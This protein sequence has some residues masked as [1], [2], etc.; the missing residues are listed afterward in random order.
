MFRTRTTLLDTLLKSTLAL[1]V[2]AL[3]LLVVF[4]AYS[5][6]NQRDA[7]VPPDP[8]IVLGK[9]L[10]VVV[11]TGDVAGDALEITGYEPRNG[12]LAAVA[13][14]R[15]RV[16]A[17]DYPLLKYQVDTEFPGPALKLVWH[18]QDSPGTLMS[19]DLRG[20]DGDSA[21][22]EL[23]RH[24]DWRGSVV[25]MGVYAYTSDARDVLSISHL[26]LVPQDWR[27]SLASY[28]S[29]LT[30]YRGWTAR[31]INKIYGSADITVLSPVLLAA[32][33]SAL[34]VILLLVAGIFSRPHPPALVAALLL[35]WIALDL[36][37]Q[38]ELMAQLIQTRDQFAGKTVI[39]KH[40]SDV[41]RHIYRYIARLKQ[42]VLPQRHARILILHD[43]HAHNFVRL[44][45]QYYLL[46][47]NV[48]NFGVVPPEAGLK[49]ID[50]VL[51]LGDVPRLQYDAGAQALLWKRGR[52]ALPV[53]LLDDDFMGKLYRVL[54]RSGDAQEAI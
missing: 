31:T 27:G 4:A 25:E 36:L 44:K 54:P 35:P 18:T 37:W 12:E 51:V 11:G 39:E 50:Y 43:S 29:D 15:G 48:Y 16:A 24:P 47:H 40:L 49:T 10:Q 32:A 33:W 34:A 21:W 38:R 6:R 52:R 3:I 45:A 30:G 9:S 53:E 8:L 19:T 28:W 41:D 2:S 13:V 22:L 14:W 42:D 5:Q 46:P 1:T 7:A 26:T 20:T 17:G 23:S